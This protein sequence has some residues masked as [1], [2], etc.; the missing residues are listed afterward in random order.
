M[1]GPKPHPHRWRPG[2]L[3]ILAAIA[4]LAIGIHWLG[5]LRPVDDHL[6]DLSMRLRGDRKPDPRI[7]I[8]A[9]DEA[10]LGGLGPWPLPRRLYADLLQRL[11]TARVVAFDILFAEPSPDDMAFDLMLQAHG[12]S[13]L[14]VYLL[15]R[16]RIVPPV[17]T[18]HPRATGHVHLEPDVDGIVRRVHHF[19]RV[20]HSAAGAISGR[21]HVRPERPRGRRPR[22]PPGRNPG[23]AASGPHR[24]ERPH[25]HQFLRAARKPMPR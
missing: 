20:A 18:L 5:F 19:L 21:G 13:V 3:A 25:G 11:M 2:P 22:R 16:G 4:A 14:P 15:P 23:A 8:V 17:A 24:P 12:R 10:A 7:L 1:S 9:V 6:Y